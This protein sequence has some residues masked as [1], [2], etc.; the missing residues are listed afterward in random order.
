MKNNKSIIILHI[1]LA[2]YSLFGIASKLAAQEEFLSFRF[3]MLYGAVI[4]NLGVYAIVW[5]QL[6]KR[7]PVITAYANKAVTVVWGILWGYLFFGE[8][9]TVLKIVGAIVIIIGVLFV[10]FDET[11]ENKNDEKKEVEAL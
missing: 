8:K 3:I 9:I 6:L 10:V 4:V 1:V 2:L 7:I 11:S 5:Q